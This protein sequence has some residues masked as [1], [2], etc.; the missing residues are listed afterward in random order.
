[1][2]LD[3]RQTDAG[4]VLSVL[5]K[6]GA[7]RDD[8]VGLHGSSLKVSVTAAPDK[9][10]ANKA[11]VKLL[12]KRLGVAPSTI[13]IVAGEMSRSKKVRVLGLRAADVVGRLGLGGIA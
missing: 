9:G 3:I 1:M 8:V 6:P 4:A 13:A 11:I 12:A 5:A 10:K 2:D 7:K